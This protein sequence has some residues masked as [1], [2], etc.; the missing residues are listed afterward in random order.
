M[1]TDKKLDKLFVFLSLGSRVR[2]VGDWAP[3]SRSGDRPVAEAREE[4]FMLMG[5]AFYND[6]G[7]TLAVLG[8]SPEDVGAKA[9]D[10]LQQSSFV[11]ALADLKDVEFAYTF[12]EPA[13]TWR[14]I[15]RMDRRDG[16]LTLVREADEQ[17][18]T[19]G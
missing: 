5:A 13:R 3:A 15:G 2:L 7:S 19:L 10:L 17:P 14:R 1:N 16:K 12:D 9:W 4:S 18:S 11:G 8:S 6:H